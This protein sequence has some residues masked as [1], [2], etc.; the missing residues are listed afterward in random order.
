MDQGSAATKSTISKV[1]KS[2]TTQT[3][4]STVIKMDSR[5]GEDANWFRI[6][7]MK[8][9]FRLSSKGLKVVFNII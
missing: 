1:K 4:G 5:T 9:T 2:N 6:K 8:P 7:A 3:L